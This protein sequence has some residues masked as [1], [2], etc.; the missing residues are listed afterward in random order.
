MQDRFTRILVV[1][2]HS[3]IREALSAHL[4]RNGM[5][6]LSAA[7]AAEAREIV[8]QENIDLVVL[9]IMMPG[10]DG[11]SLCRYLR[12]KWHK[13]VIL[14][15]ALA[16]GTD[17]IVGLELGADDYVTKPFNPREL[18]ARIKAVLRRATD[19]EKTDRDRR[20]FHFGAWQ[21]DIPRGELRAADGTIV[22]L[23][24]GEVRLLSVFL[25]NPG[26]ILSRDELIDFTKG[27]DALPFDRSVDNMISRL[28]RKM[29]PDPKEPT[30]IKTVWGGGYRFTG[31]LSAF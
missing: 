25:E 13:P 5:I 15:S 19:L 12:E 18:V 10:E 6:A 27:R 7:N 20:N 31:D 21:L 3:D 30:Y 26:R 9:D 1:D 2:D 11:L 22:P 16:D 17:K 28:R 4:E 24:A 14:L 8:Q 23:S 29:E